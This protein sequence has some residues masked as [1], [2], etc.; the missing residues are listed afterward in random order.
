M[1]LK[2][3]NLIIVTVNKM[4]NIKYVHWFHQKKIDGEDP[5]WCLVNLVSNNNSVD[6]LKEALKVKPDMQGVDED[7][8][9]QAWIEDD[10]IN[11]IDI[12]S[13]DSQNEI[14]CPLCDA[15]FG[16]PDDFSAHVETDCAETLCLKCPICARDINDPEELVIHIDNEH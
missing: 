1:S 4:A 3:Q 6:V 2:A 10:L 12:D 13:D 11:N 5:F 15:R 16:S 7:E 9:N 8:A 14:S